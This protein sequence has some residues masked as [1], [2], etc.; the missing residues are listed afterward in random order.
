MGQYFRNLKDEVTDLE[1]IRHTLLHPR[2]YKFGHT[3]GKT[4]LQSP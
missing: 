1:N 2:L 4:D 3:S